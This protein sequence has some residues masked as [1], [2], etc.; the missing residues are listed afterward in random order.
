MIQR[1]DS[2]GF[3]EIMRGKYKV[4][5]TDYIVKLLTGMTTV[6]RHKLLYIPFDVLWEQ[7]WGQPTNGGHAYKNEKEQ[8][9]QKLE[10][11]KTA[12]PS[13]DDLISCAPTTW[14][15]PEWGFPK[16]RRDSNESEYACAMRELWEETN[17][18]ESQ[19]IPIR[20]LEP[21]SERFFGSN[22]VHYCHKYFIAFAPEEFAQTVSYE[23]AVATNEHISREVGDMRWFSADEALSTIR[24]EN[25]E[26][27]E[28]LLRVCSLLRNYCPLRLPAA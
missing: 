10:L 8:A 22:Q 13:L 2:I 12:T 4:T 6:E 26:K 24:P 20:N 5:D 16:G 18:Q 28:I 7:L 17:I 3:V 19:I 21:I 9:K 14:T 15:T 11:L 25:V 23:R 1:R 27:R